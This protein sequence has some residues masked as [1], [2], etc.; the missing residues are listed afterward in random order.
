MPYT[1]VL[2]GLTHG[3]GRALLDEFVQQGHTVIGCGRSKEKIEELKKKFPSPRRFDALDVSNAQQ[4]KAWAADV[5]KNYPAPDFLINNAGVINQLAPLW[6]VPSEEFNNVV[7]VNICG[8]ANTIRAFA[9]AMIERKKGVIINFS[10][11]WGKSVDAEVAP[12][13]ASKFAVEGLSQALQL[14]LPQ[15]M[16]SIAFNPGVINTEMLQSCFGKQAENYPPP[17]EWAK[18][19]AQ[20]ILSF[21]NF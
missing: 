19:T 5:L 8:V 14:E 10:S 12:Y 6:K 11:G 16:K 3:C 4:V 21:A 1:I 9:P 2:T 13:C 7:N 18:T 20:K 15:G 17:Q